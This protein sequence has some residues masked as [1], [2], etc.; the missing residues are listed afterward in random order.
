MAEVLCEAVDPHG[1]ERV[2]DVAC[3][4][5]TAALVAARRYCEVTGIDYVPGLIE[6]A[7]G[8]AAADGLKADF[9]VEDAQN[10]P[11]PDG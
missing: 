9:R 2:L 7:K 8:R 10:L 1:G 11:F 5:G 6:R 3:G 4:S